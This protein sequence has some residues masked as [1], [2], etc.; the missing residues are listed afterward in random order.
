MNELFITA[1]I[2]DIEARYPEFLRAKDLIK[3]GLFRSPAAITLAVK[4]GIAPPSMSLSP[5]RVAF[6]RASLCAWLRQKA[7]QSR[8]TR[9]DK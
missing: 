9:F 7:N 2:Q 8:E 5:K 6:P 1:L 4:N 3:L